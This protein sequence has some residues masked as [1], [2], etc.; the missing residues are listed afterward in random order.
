MWITASQL[1]R[2]LPSVNPYH[3][4]T[5]QSKAE[6]LEEKINDLESAIMSLGAERVAAFIAEP[7]LASGGVIIPPAVIIAAH[8]KYANAMMCFISDEVVSAFGR[9]GHWFAS[10]EV[11]GIQPDIITCAKG[12]TSGYIPMGACLISE[13][14]FAPLVGG[15]ECVAGDYSDDNLQLH[16]TVGARIDEHC[17]E[18]GLIVRPALQYVRILAAACHQR[19]TN[20]RDV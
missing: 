15:V 8:G 6:F 1:V 4:P 13:R 3:R 17:Q 9:L 11:F 12:L 7:L 20:K 18:L 10:E 19:K 2:F 5:E 14:V 16:K